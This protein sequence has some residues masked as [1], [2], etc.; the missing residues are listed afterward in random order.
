NTRELI[1]RL[2]GDSKIIITTIQ[3]LNT[4]I[5]KDYY[6]KHLQKV[7]GQRVVMIFDECH[8]SHFGESHKNIVRFFNNLQLFGFTGTPIFVENAKQ[9]HTT[10]EFFGDCLHRYLIKDAIADE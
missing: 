8:R 2:S 1:H 9:D 7:R 6:N 3:K 5:I 4:A 10:A